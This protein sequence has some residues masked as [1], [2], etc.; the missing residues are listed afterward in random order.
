MKHKDEIEEIKSLM[1]I[2]ASSDSKNYPRTIYD[3][4]FK[5]GVTYLPTKDTSLSVDIIVDSGESYKYNNHPLCL[6]VVDGENVHPVTIS[7][8]PSTIGGYQIPDDVRDFIEQNISVLIDFANMKIDGPNFFALLNAWKKGGNRVSI[9]A[10]MSN[11]GPEST[12]LPVW[13]YIDDTG[14]WKISGHNQ[15]YRMKFQQDRN[16]S[17]PRKWMPISIPSLQVMDKE[18]VPPCVI[19]QRKINKVIEWA[20]GNL[21]LLTKL[22]DGKI[23]GAEFAQQMRK[24]SEIKVLF[25]SEN[26]Q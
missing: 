24:M 16:I 6:F 13:V 3:E 2:I 19:P 11:Y 18:S 9:V 25:D 8:N 14:S 23:S 21:D 1:N 10:E 5:E 4:E 17:S 12:E 15:S 22:R 26:H 7:L 20:R